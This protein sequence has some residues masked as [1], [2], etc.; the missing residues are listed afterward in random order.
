[1]SVKWVS[2]FALFDRL[3]GYGRVH[4]CDR[5]AVAVDTDGVD[6]GAGC[7]LV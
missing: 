4:N 5:D 6:R 7:L 2:V 1:M 3:A